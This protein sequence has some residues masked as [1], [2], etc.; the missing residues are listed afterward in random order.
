MNLEGFA[1]DGASALVSWDAPPCPNAPITGYNIYYTMRSFAQNG[2]IDSTGYSVTQITST[3]RMLSEIVTGLDP[4]ASYVFH[5]RAFY[6]NSTNG[7]SEG[8]A[9]EEIVVLIE[10]QVVLPPSITDALNELGETDTNSLVIGLPSA[11]AF[12]DSGIE[13]IQ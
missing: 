5:V 12:A 6:L 4:G 13:D 1:N 11:D 2:T 7:T 10:D 8:D 3:A 9:F